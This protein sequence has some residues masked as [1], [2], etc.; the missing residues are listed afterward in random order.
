MAISTIKQIRFTTDE[1]MRM[2]EAGVFDGRRVELLQGRIREMHAQCNAHMACISLCMIVFSRHFNDR[3][4]HWLVGQG[5]YRIGP[6]D[7]PDPDFVLFDVPVG[8]PDDR[9][10]LPSLVI[11]VA[12][13]SYKR[14][15]GI[16]LRRYAAAGVP[17]YWIINLR[18]ARVEVYRGPHNPN[19][20]ARDWQ[21]RTVEYYSAGS[22][23]Q[24]LAFP[25]IEVSV[26]DLIP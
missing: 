21:Y 14:D 22:K 10:P 8:T 25:S 26:A 5:T 6:W 18:L 13:S 2:S 17:D 19:G 15:S 1:Y 7:A 16:K 11:E 12:Q 3:S 20:L 9:L 4:R 24:L 23:I